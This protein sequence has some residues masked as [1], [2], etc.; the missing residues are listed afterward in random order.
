MADNTR[1]WNWINFIKNNLEEATI[2]QE[3]FVA[4]DL[5]WYPVEG[6]NKIRVAPDVMVAFGRPKGDRNSYLQWR[7]DNVTPTIVFEILSPGNTKKEMAK[8]LLF[9][10]KYLVEEY[11]VYDPLL[12]TLEIYQRKGK[13]LIDVTTKNWISPLMKFRMRWAEDTLEMYHADGRPFLSH[14]ELS[15][16]MKAVEVEMLKAKSEA[17]KA[18]KK[19][20]LMAAKLK[21][22]GIDPNT[23]G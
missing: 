6:N 12:N 14:I 23:L 2:G 22:L 21:A 20:E 3:T 11:Y 16:K 5:F 9:Y 17:D 19:A 4:S 7:E 15:E 13:K 1:Q 8:K 18:N 10:Q